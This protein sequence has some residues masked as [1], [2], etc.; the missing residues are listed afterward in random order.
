MRPWILSSPPVRTWQPGVVL[1]VLWLTPGLVAQKKPAPDVAEVHQAIDRGVQYLLETQSLEGRWFFRNAELRQFQPLGRPGA[2]ALAL[3]AL[4]KSG[5]PK[6]HLA[7]QRGFAALEHEE[8][9]Q[10]YDASAVI[11]ALLARGEK[12]DR[13]AIGGLVRQLLD[14]QHNG[15]W[16]YPSIPGDLSNTQYAA[17]ALWSAERAG[18]AM[19]QSTWIDL[20]DALPRYADRRG[21]F[22][23]NFG[24]GAR[25]TPSMTAAGLMCLSVCRHTLASELERDPEL[26]GSLDKLEKKAEKWLGSRFQRKGFKKLKENG[27]GYYLY[28]V[29]RL[30]ALSGKHILGEAKEGWYPIGARFLVG[31]QR[32]DG[33]WS[34]LYGGSTGTSFALLFLTRATGP[35]TPLRTWP[36]A[37]QQDPQ[38]GDSAAAQDP[39][40]PHL[41]ALA[42]DATRNIMP[43]R[44]V[45]AKASTTHKKQRAALAMDRDRT[46]AWESSERDKNPRLMIVLP[47]PVKANVVKIGEAY[48]RE[49]RPNPLAHA[50][51]VLVSVN[52]GPNQDVRMPDHPLGRGTL[53]LPTAHAISELLIT[54]PERI[55]APDGTARVGISEI[56]LQLTR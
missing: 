51:R 47:Y 38:A 7:I 55:P 15:I 24:R 31:E 53:V 56:E 40:N 52:G 14:S 17:L 45:T 50:P 36:G 27:L 16:G 6:D 43:L 19:G 4:L 22:V 28:G 35:T 37:D 44:G 46:T 26:K 3:H 1:S 5:V 39:D 30:G 33:S 21:G 13:I 49:G 2:T 9:D 10:T 20:A 12:S 54:F 48:R 25:A 41:V 11:L 42:R 32:E 18:F 29:E 8:I 34:H 23:Y